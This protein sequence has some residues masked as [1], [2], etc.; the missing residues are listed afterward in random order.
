MAN[1]EEFHSKEQVWSYLSDLVDSS[2]SYNLYQRKYPRRLPKLDDFTSSRH[3]LVVNKNKYQCNKKLGKSATMS[4]AS[5]TP[6]KHLFDYKDESSESKS[7]VEAHEH[8]VENLSKMLVL[9]DIQDDD[10]ET[11]PSRGIDLPHSVCSTTVK[12]N[13]ESV[14]IMSKSKT[15]PMLQDI[16]TDFKERSP[17]KNN[18]HKHSR[19]TSLMPPGIKSHQKSISPLSI[20]PETLKDDLKQFSHVS[21]KNSLEYTSRRTPSPRKRISI[22][23]HSVSVASSSSGRKSQP[24]NVYSTVKNRSS[25]ENQQK[26]KS[27]IHSTSSKQVSK[28]SEK[29]D[30]LLTLLCE[31]KETS[32]IQNL[33]K[34]EK[35]KTNRRRNTY[36]YNISTNEH[37]KTNCSD[38]VIEIDEHSG[39][40]LVKSVQF[41]EPEVTNDVILNPQSLDN[42]ESWNCV[43]KRTS[44]KYSRE[45]FFSNPLVVNSQMIFLDKKTSEVS[46]QII[47]GQQFKGE[48]I[49]AQVAITLRMLLFGTGL[50]SFTSSWVD[51]SI[52]YAKEDHYGLLFSKDGP[53]EIMASLQAYILK[54][55]LFENKQIK[56][57]DPNLLT[58]SHLAQMNILMISISDMLWKI[59]GKI[60]AIVSLPLGKKSNFT[61]DYNYKDDDIT[62]EMELF[63]FTKI[64]DLKLFIKQN[65]HLFTKPKSNGCISLLYSLMLTRGLSNLHLDC[66]ERKL[67][68]LESSYVSERSQSLINL[69]IYGEGVPNVFNKDVE[70]YNDMKDLIEIQKGLHKRSEI[71]YL[72]YSECVDKKKHS[73]GSCL[74][75]PQ[76]PIWILNNESSLGVLFSTKR[77]LLNDWKL[78]RRFDMFYY[79][80]VAKHIPTTQ[81]DVR[82]TLNTIETLN[83]KED[84]EEDISTF[85]ETLRTKYKDSVIDWN[86]YTRF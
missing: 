34:T 76:L 10:N 66:C 18:K 27:S 8:S 75:T 43:V 22:R 67:G 65:I 53:V 55:L 79:Q 5:L 42:N 84:E 32:C 57:F 82:L 7:V 59:G 69:C 50:V 29:D 11:T 60:R 38:F 37:E 26:R 77:N 61:S 56:E 58:P 4:S 45:S 47:N 85:E 54:H 80:G 25:S 74:K 40:Q 35:I 49:S 73:V 62:E 13:Q 71:G 78:E 36:H 15:K 1:D 17:L 28:S 9:E 70:I 41:A 63:K 44:E 24:L 6:I 21:T 20:L 68:I 52:S 86:G 30:N 48:P 51:Q 46:P 33:T 72:T 39:V 12:L 2:H 64:D 16:V 19:P 83:L 14:L 3:Q 81:Y 23:S 31:Q